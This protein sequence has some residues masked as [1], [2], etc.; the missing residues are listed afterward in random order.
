MTEKVYL[1]LMQP[2]VNFLETL[3]GT[4]LAKVGQLAFAL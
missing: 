1:N 4:A 3:M 2:S